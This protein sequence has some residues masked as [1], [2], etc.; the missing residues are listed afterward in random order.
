MYATREEYLDAMDTFPKITHYFE[1][2]SETI[3][4]LDCDDEGEIIEEVIFKDLLTTLNGFEEAVVVVDECHDGEDPVV[5][6]MELG[7]DVERFE[8]AYNGKWD[9]ELAYA[10]DLVDSCYDLEKMMG[11]LSSYFD[12]EKF[13]RDL[14]ITDYTYCDGYVFNNNY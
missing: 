1:L 11:S 7:H 8:E 6:F 9:S 3:G 13:A 4:L 2:T 5:T 14:F 10:E 12:Y